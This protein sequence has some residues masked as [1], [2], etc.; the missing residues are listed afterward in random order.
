VLR[1]PGF[2]VFVV[3]N[4]R[5]P[6]GE[7]VDFKGDTRKAFERCGLAYH[8]EIVYRRP[9]GTAPSRTYCFRANRRTVRNH[10]YVLVMRKGTLQQFRDRDRGG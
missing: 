4:F 2:A 5:G 10:E 7:I 3:G 9:L 6:A 8:D 1:E